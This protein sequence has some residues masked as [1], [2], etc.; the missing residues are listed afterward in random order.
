MSHY[1]TNPNPNPGELPKMASL[2][3]LGAS[4]TVKIVVYSAIAILATLESI[5]WAKA[6]YQWFFKK[7]EEQSEENKDS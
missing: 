5:F 3:D 4:R 1:S 2:S 7:A 6:G